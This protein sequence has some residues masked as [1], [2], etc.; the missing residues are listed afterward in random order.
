ML[1]HGLILD[2]VYGFTSAGRLKQDIQLTTKKVFFCN[3]GTFAN[4]TE[5]CFRYKC[6]TSDT[7]GNFPGLRA[8]ILG[9]LMVIKMEK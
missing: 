1:Y 5:T 8:V 9:M 7:R 2:F 3:N 4:I 6:I